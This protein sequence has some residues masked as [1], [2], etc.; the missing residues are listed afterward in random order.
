MSLEQIYNDVVNGEMDEV[1][2]GVIAA[3]AAGTAAER[4]LQEGL[5]AAMDQIGK[6][7]EEGEIFVPEMLFAA[8]AMQAGMKVLKPALA[9]SEVK[10]AG[11]VAIG[12]VQGDL[13]D[14]G[15]NL[16][17]MMLEGAGFEVVDLGTDVPAERFVEAARGGAQ[18]IGISALLTTT[19][20]AMGRT[21]EALQAA[22]VRERVKVVIGGAPVTDAYAQKIGADAYAA[23]A[24]VATRIVRQLISS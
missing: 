4:I 10:S 1:E 9:A 20:P 2:T 13:H 19:M 22:G 16:V 11:K 8:R 23:D 18:V 14:I 21:V 17:I 3:L 7:F 15:K 12:T 6:L 24:S 5:I